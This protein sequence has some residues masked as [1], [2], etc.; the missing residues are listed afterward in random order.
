MKATKALKRL[1]K[2]EASMSDVVERYVSLAPAVRKALQHALAAV[3][4]A[5]KAV[6]LE[7]TSGTAKDLPVEPPEP[8]SKAIPR[9]PKTKR[10]PSV[11]S[12]RKKVI[13]APVKAPTK[14]VGP[15][16]EVVP[17]KKK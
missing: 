6:N 11:A 17:V 12:A 7:A 3:T 1:T 9:H 10:P 8:T 14:K 4:V 16:K 13:M 5:K 2:I 15:I